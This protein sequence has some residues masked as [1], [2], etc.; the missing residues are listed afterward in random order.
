VSIAW[1]GVLGKAQTLDLTSTLPNPVEVGE[2]Y[3]FTLNYTSEVSCKIAVALIKSTADGTT[4]DW[5]S[6]S[7]QNGTF[8]NDLP[9]TATPSSQSTSVSIPSSVIPSNQLTGGVQYLWAI[10]LQTSSGDWITGSFHPVTVNTSSTVSNTINFNGTIPTS[11]SQGE[12]AKI[13]YQYTADSNGII[14]VALSKYNSTGAW[15]SDVVSEIINPASET[16][17]NAVVGEASLVI[18]ND[19]P[20]SSTLTDGSMYKWEVS[21]FTTEWSYLAGA[22]TQVSVE[23]NLAVS[24][25]VKANKNFVFPNPAKDVVY[26]SD[27]VQAKTVTITDASGKVVFTNSNKNVKEVNISNLQNGVYFVNINGNQSQKIIKK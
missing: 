11:I 27:A 22:Q 19:T 2:T 10:M 21:L 6:G 8:I 15:E 14:K 12:T 16:T 7:W 17:S 5:G 25:L 9:A 18:P 3:N 23:A 26:I 20:I 13:G 4:P 24:D 1:I